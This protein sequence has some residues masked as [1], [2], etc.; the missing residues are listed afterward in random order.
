[1]SIIIPLKNFKRPTILLYDGKKDP[2]AHIQTNRTWMNIEKADAPILC[3]A[4]PLTLSRPAH[5]WFGRL[6]VGTISNFKKLKEQFIAQF[7]S[8][9]PQNRESNYL[10][11]IHQKDGESMRE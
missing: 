2:V 10:K 5:A 8:S 1:M 4:F 6:H 9:R 7:L 3:N 11:T